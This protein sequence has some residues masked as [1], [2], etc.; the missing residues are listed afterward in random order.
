MRRIMRRMAKKNKLGIALIIIVLSFTIGVSYA[1]WTDTLI[2]SSIFTTGSFDVEYADK[3]VKVDMVKM[4]GEKIIKEE[5]VKDFTY[6]ISADKK[7][8]VLNVNDNLINNLKDSN[9]MLRIKNPLITSEDSKVTA[10]KPKDID[11]SQADD[12]FQVA[13]KELKLILDGNTITNDLNK[14]E[15]NI[16]FDIYKGVE[17]RTNLDSP[18]YTLI[19][20]KA[21]NLNEGNIKMEYDDLKVILPEYNDIS[22]ENPVITEAEIEAEYS[23]IIPIGVD[24]FNTE[25]KG[26]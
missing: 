24:Q 22:Y 26:S 13:P 20:L 8:I 9:Y 5:S 18:Y 23:L 2:I 14:E 25:N 15:Y 16:S 1:Y 19:Y 10:I 7:S 11:F 4:D 12:S 3:E 17:E 21:T 6:T